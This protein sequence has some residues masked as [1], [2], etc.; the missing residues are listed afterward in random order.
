MNFS[1]LASQMSPVWPLW[2][3]FSQVKRSAFAASV[4]CPASS[5]RRSPLHLTRLRAPLEKRKFTLRR[6]S[7]QYLRAARRSR[8]G[9]SS[10]NGPV[11]RFSSVISRIWLF[12][13]RSLLGFA[14]GAPG[15]SKR[16]DLTGGSPPLSGSHAEGAPARKDGSAGS[17]ASFSRRFSR[18]GRPEV[19]GFGFA[20]A[21]KPNAQVF[22]FQ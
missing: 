17:C 13:R 21:L 19:L 8:L 18:F 9:G 12:P 1:H 11:G 3:S 2:R 20:P 15:S 22:S 16:G 14:G 6:T 10:I 7:L 4:Q 5:R